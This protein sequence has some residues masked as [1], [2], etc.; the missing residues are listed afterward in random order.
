MCVF[1]YEIQFIVLNFTVGVV[2]TINHYRQLFQITHNIARLNLSQI[3]E[4]QITYKDS[5]KC[6][7]NMFSK[8]VGK[9][10]AKFKVHFARNCTYIGSFVWENE[11]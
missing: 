3:S 5:F 9:L 1:K 4:L 8:L 10:I 11:E 2:Y 6:Y 7:Y